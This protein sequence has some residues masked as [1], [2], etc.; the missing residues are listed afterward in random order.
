MC[1]FFFLFVTFFFVELAKVWFYFA[2]NHKV[3]AF[4]F[5]IQMAKSPCRLMISIFLFVFRANNI[6][7]L[8]IIIFKVSKYHYETFIYKTFSKVLLCFHVQQ[9]LF[10]V[11]FHFCVF[12]FGFFVSRFVS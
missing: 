10:I 2:N 8:C 12:I 6:F 3:F 7:Y 11:F 9:K 1:V 5:S 4:F